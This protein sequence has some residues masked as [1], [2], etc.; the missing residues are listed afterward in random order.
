[1]KVYTWNVLNPAFVPMTWAR[2]ANAERLVLE[3]RARTEY[4]LGAIAAVVRTWLRGPVVVCLQEVWPELRAALKAE[5]G[6]RMAATG[7]ADSRV[8]LVSGLRIAA[9]RELHLPG[10]PPKSA[11]VCALELG[12]R[13]FECANVHLHWKWVDLTA[14]AG[15]LRGAEIVAGDFNKEWGALGAFLRGRR[16]VALQDATAVNPTTNNLAAIDHVLVSSRFN[17]P[18]TRVVRAAAGY[19]LMYDFEAVAALKTRWVRAK[20][21]VSDHAPLE[22]VVTFKHKTKKNVQLHVGAVGS[23]RAGG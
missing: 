13:R 23:R 17:A 22:S 21:D 3:D 12:G 20:K 18:K 15:A 14:A 16:G 9:A 2:Y 1:M 5:H 10:E 4:R 11:L 8:T 19:T 6:A 7:G